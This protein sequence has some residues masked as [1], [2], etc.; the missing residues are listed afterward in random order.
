VVVASANL[1]NFTPQ[2]SYPLYLGR[3]PSD[4]SVALYSGLMDE[5][6]IHDRA[7]SQTEIITLYI[8]GKCQS[9]FSFCP[10]A[11]PPSPMDWSSDVPYHPGS[12]GTGAQDPVNRTIWCYC[13]GAGVRGARIASTSANSL[14]QLPGGWVDWSTEGGEGDLHY[15][16]NLNNLNQ[17]KMLYLA[18]ACC[19]FPNA[20]LWYFVSQTGTGNHLP[21]PIGTR[22]VNSVGFSAAANTAYIPGWDSVSSA[23]A[24]ISVNCGLANPP[25]QVTGI[26]RFT[27]VPQLAFGSCVFAD[28]VNKLIIANWTPDNSFPFWY[29]DPLNPTVLRQ[30]TSVSGQASSVESPEVF[31]VDELGVV[32]MYIDKPDT[33]HSLVVIDPKSDHLVHELAFSA[34][35]NPFPRGVCFNR[36]SQVLY[37]STGNYIYKFD[38]SNN[39]QQIG[40][41]ITAGYNLGHLYYDQASNLVYGQERS[42]GYTV[43]MH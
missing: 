31:Y 42:G 41:P 32:I 3:R 5:L 17:T 35:G 7:L 4:L 21:L 11:S 22:T 18:Q 26:Q 25:V 43:H 28:N 6:T 30:S 13:F 33:S 19:S 8:S 40:D 27:G 2:T 1:G 39:Y 12:I 34:F 37:V 9:P 20:T 24:I 23:S 38:P 10:S 14:V 16:P 29:Y 36:C 15:A